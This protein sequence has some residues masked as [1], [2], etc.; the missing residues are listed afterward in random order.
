MVSRWP[1]LA[2]WASFPPTQLA[3][4]Y[5]SV[6]TFKQSINQSL[7]AFTIC[8]HWYC[9]HRWSLSFVAASTNVTVTVFDQCHTTVVS[10]CH[11]WMWSV[12]VVRDSSSKQPA[13]WRLQHKLVTDGRLWLATAVNNIDWWPHVSVDVGSCCH[14]LLSLATVSCRRRLLLVVVDRFCYFLHHFRSSP[15]A[16]AVHHCNQRYCWFLLDADTAGCRWSL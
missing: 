14:G 13:T 15:V 5:L 4:I 8:C 11:R 3:Q 2:N 16:V 10:H 12:T 7:V 1:S 9:Q 6:L